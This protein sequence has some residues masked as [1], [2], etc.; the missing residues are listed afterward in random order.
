MS[1]ETYHWILGVCVAVLALA[2]LTQAIAAATMLVTLRPLI[3]Q[4]LQAVAQGKLLAQ[5][6][7]E[8]F[9]TLK[10]QLLSTSNAAKQIA[11]TAKGQGTGLVQEWRTAL[12][13][14]RNIKERAKE[15]RSN[16]PQS[17]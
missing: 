13:P 5:H 16:T 4:S 17:R 11:L 14:V 12:V 10:P 3:T 1:I 6:S 9:A 8:L 15:F 7:K 2:M